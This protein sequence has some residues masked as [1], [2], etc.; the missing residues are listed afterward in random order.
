LKRKLIKYLKYLAISAI[1]WIAFHWYVCESVDWTFG[2]YTFPPYPDQV[3]PACIYGWTQSYDQTPY[4]CPMICGGMPAVGLY[5]GKPPVAYVFPPQ[6]EPAWGP[7]T[8]RPERRPLALLYICWR[9]FGM[10]LG[11]AI[12]LIPL[13]LIVMFLNWDDAGRQE[14]FWRFVNKP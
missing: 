13:V 4:W 3:A 11:F 9:S 1:C 7:I 5:Q 12:V 10:L 14:S 2:S 6:N 8:V